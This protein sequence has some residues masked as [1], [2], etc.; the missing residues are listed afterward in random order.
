MREARV[1]VAL[2]L[3]GCDLGNSGVSVF[4]EAVIP[5]LSAHLESRGVASIVLGT[6]RER[7]A[8]KLED[9]P[10]PVL[11][12]FLDKAGVSAAFVLGG[13]TLLARALGASLL[14]LPC[15]NRRIVGLPAVPVAGTVH[16]LAQ[17]HVEQKY[18]PLRELYVRRV[19]TPLLTSMRMV[20]AVS[21]ATA[22]D[23]E[24]HA[25]VARDRIRVIPN[26]LTLGRAASR[27]ESDARAPYFLY[28][29][30]LEH[31][32]KNHVRVLEAFA[33][34]RARGTHR[35]VFTGADW[36]AEE[37]IRG[38]IASLSLEDRVE[39][40]GFVSRDELTTRMAGA[41]AVIAAGL[42]EGFGL[43]A[44]EALA[45]GRP[46]AASATGSL[47][48]VVG[49]LGALFD[50]TDVTSMAGALDRV[51]E[52][53]VLRARCRSEGPGHAAKFSW[54]KTA[55]QIGDALCEVLDAAA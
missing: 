53:E 23:V 31:P 2:S 51:V 17:F 20:T 14:Y 24:R 34:S 1:T 52:D 10:G 35:L 6:A 9:A 44:A 32:G 7:R 21:Q 25:G 27:S 15:A 41:D 42:F 12:A 40:A 47:P 37:R 29:A 48:E 45:L 19:L 36:G 26:G 18:G 4:A 39:I 16:D 33:R 8:A 43:P 22:D 13:A 49:S 30:R 5:R 11:P 55:A 3:A 46:I 28:P 38:V 50:P 54:D